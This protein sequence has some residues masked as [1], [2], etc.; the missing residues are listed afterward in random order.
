MT[1]QCKAPGFCPLKGRMVRH[2][3]I[4]SCKGSFP[5]RKRTSDTLACQ[6]AG[7]G[8]CPVFHRAMDQADYDVCSGA[9]QWL[10]AREMARWLQP[11]AAEA[12]RSCVYDNGQAFDEHGLPLKRRTCGCNGQKPVILMKNCMHPSHQDPMPEGCESRCSHFIRVEPDA[13]DGSEA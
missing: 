9:V 2:A 1:C 12:G 6:C 13:L 8:D 7:P 10:K 5:V 3:D 11:S 4:Q